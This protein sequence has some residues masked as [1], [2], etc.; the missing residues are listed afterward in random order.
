VVLIDL[1][2][3]HVVLEVHLDYLHELQEL[4][5]QG[6][7]FTLRAGDLHFYYYLKTADAMRLLNSMNKGMS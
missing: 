7:T 4:G 1:D 5:W 3:K 2:D 6:Q